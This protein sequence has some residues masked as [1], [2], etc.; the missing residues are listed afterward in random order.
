M[1]AEFKAV[2]QVER[3]GAQYFQIVFADRQ[4]IVWHVLVPVNPTAE[5]LARSLLAASCLASDPQKSVEL[6]IISQEDVDK[7]RMTLLQL[8]SMPEGKPH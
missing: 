6:G 1:I 5:Q 2:L 4:G 3:D 8:R 7:A